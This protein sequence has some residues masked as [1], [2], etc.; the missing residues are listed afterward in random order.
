L[1]LLDVGTALLLLIV[2]SVALA[3]QLQDRAPSDG[4][5][6]MTT[7]AS[8]APV[9]SIAAT[10][11]TGL[12]VTT[13]VAPPT[14][15]TI[16]PSGT[17]VVAPGGTFQAGSGALRTYRVEVEASTGVDPVAFAAEV[18]AALSD[19]RSWIADGS[20]ALQRVETGGEFRI[21]LATPATT[22]QLCAPLQTNSRYSC[23]QGGDAVINLDRWHGA[24]DHWTTGLPTYRQMVVNHEVGHVLGHDHLGCPGAGQPA[25]VMQQQTKGLDGCLE[26]PWPFP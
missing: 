15:V 18:D 16:G 1:V 5:E 8:A 4:A 25:P 17:F 7:T 13:T 11:T 6:L 19:P 20:V 24:V 23:E 9:S 2:G 3:S 22:D 26:N 10:T 21:V 12:P 14:P